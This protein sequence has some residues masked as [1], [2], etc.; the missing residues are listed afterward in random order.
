MEKI[1]AGYSGLAANLD[2]VIQQSAG[3]LVGKEHLTLVEIV[4]A[5]AVHTARAWTTDEQFIR[6]LDQDGQKLRKLYER[7]K[8]Y[9]SVDEGE[10]Y[11]LTAGSV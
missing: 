11:R 5:A 8:P 10:W 1:Y 4:T 3:K 9:T 2:E 7:V 6:I